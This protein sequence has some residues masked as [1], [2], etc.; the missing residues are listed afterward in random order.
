[1]PARGIWVVG[2]A[3]WLVSLTVTDSGAD[4]R[5]TIWGRAGVETVH[6]ESTQCQLVGI[7][8]WNGESSFQTPRGMWCRQLLPRRGA[9]GA[10]FP[11]GRKS[12]WYRPL[13]DR[14]LVGCP[15]LFSS[16]PPTPEQF[17]QFWNTKVQISPLETVI[18]VKI[19]ARRRRARKF[20]G[21]GQY[22]VIPKFRAGRISGG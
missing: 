10:L 4:E 2:R 13:G 17:L 12:A 18:L 5:M 11:R 21:F 22:D 14:A 15:A 20:W 9:R 16:A 7:L 6:S 3:S 1:M 19:F 8:P